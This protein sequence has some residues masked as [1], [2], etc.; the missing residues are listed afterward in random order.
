MSTHDLPLERRT[1]HGHFGTGRSPVLEIEDGDTVIFHTLDASWGTEAE[2]RGELSLEVE[3]DEVLDSGHALCGPVFVRGAEPGDVLE[4]R[5]GE[6][7]PGTWGWTWAGPRPHMAYDLR[8]RQNVSVGWRIDPEACTATDMEGLG[9]TVPIRPFMGVMGNAP[10]E[11]GP[12]STAPPRAVGGNL[13]CRHLTAGAVLWLPVEVQGALFSTGDGHALQADGEAS[14][15]A[16]ECPM[17]R[18]ELTFR[19]RK[20]MALP[21]PAAQTAAGYLRMGMGYDL[22]SA[23]ASALDQM[24]GHIEEEFALPR[25]EAMVMASLVVDLHITQIANGVRGVHALLPDGAI[26]RRS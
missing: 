11:E 8:V 26:S 15:T 23:A 22:D 9:I 19:V 25:P 4:V 12:L 13:D 1:L 10:I 24:V 20:D 18:V 3:R 16:M 17:E 5:I 2:R 6:I 21:Y 7:R 14:N